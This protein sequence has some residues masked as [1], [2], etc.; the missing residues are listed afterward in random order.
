MNMH[1]TEQDLVL[2]VPRGGS[3]PTS[4]VGMP[5]TG[6]SGIGAVALRFMA[7]R[8]TD[9]TARRGLGKRRARDRG[10]PWAEAMLVPLPTASN[11]ACGSRPVRG[12]AAFCHVLLPFGSRQHTQG[13]YCRRNHLGS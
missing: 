11:A 4:T 8:A 1:R 7:V 3:V 12:V 5:H 2:V 9:S 10:G 13:G 6:H